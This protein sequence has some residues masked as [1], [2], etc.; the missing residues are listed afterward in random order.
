MPEEQEPVHHLIQEAVEAEEVDQPDRHGKAGAKIRSIAILIASVAALITS[1]GAFFRPQDHSVQQASYEELS[2]SITA[3]Y[4]E[5]QKNHDD[6]VALRTYLADRSGEMFILPSQLAENIVTDAGPSHGPLVLKPFITKPPSSRDAGASQT[7]SM[8][9][10]LVAASA[11]PLPEVQP[12]VK[13]PPA[14][15]NQIL[16]NAR[17]VK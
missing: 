15:F 12:F 4:E 8:M 6:I 7:S 16:V 1:I 13:H 9:S 10:T 17:S 14:A 5:Q 11:Q 2:K 3:A